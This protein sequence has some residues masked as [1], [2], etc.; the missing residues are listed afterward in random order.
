MK[1]TQEQN[2]IINQQWVEAPGA[3]V[4]APQRAVTQP[5]RDPVYLARREAQRPLDKA[6][7]TTL[8]N[9]QLCHFMGQLMDSVEVI[10]GY[11]RI[12]VVKF[13]PLWQ[14]DPIMPVPLVEF[15]GFSGWLHKLAFRDMAH[16]LMALEDRNRIVNQRRWYK[17]AKA[18]GRAMI[19]Y[20]RDFLSVDEAAFYAEQVIE[21]YTNPA[22]REWK[23]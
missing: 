17:A 5:K 21:T 14:I 20:S 4:P 15:S 7:A 18:N 8:A 3:V 6:R 11:G 22:R 16:L 19:K 12:A 2:V 13:L 1:Q 9:R 10:G 23:V